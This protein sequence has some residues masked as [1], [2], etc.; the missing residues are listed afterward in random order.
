MNPTSL[1]LADDS[2]VARGGG[3]DDPFASPEGFFVK[4]SR[5][6]RKIPFIRQVDESDCGAACLAMVCRHFGRAV[7]LA[8][9]RDLTRTSASGTSLRSLCR[10]A[11]AL[12]LAARAVKTPAALLDRMP[13]PAIL[14]WEGNHWVLLY[15]VDAKNA[16]LADP[17]VGL[18]RVTR[19]ELERAFTGYAALFDYTTAFADSPVSQPGFAW[20]TAFLRPHARLVAQAIAL[21]VMVSVLELSFPVFTQLIVDR[22]IVDHN[23]T[24]LHTVVIAMAA[25]LGITVIA[26][27]VQRYLLSFV[28]VR[29]DGI[30]LDF[31]T[32]KLL[33]LPLPYF[34]ARRTGD[35]QRRLAS[36][37]EVRSFVVESGTAGLTAAANLVMALALMAFYSPRLFAVFLVTA[38][39]YAILMRYSS[40]RLGPIYA[41]LEAA[42]AKYGSQQIDAIKGIETVKTASAEASL[43]ARMIDQF[44]AVAR[45]QFHADFTMMSFDGAVRVVMFLSTALFL[46]IGAGE[47]MEGRLTLG[48]MVAW[49]AL[50][51]MANAPIATFLRIWDDLQLVSVLVNR[52]R[53]VFEHAPEQHDRR[54]H[55]QPVRSI[56][57][58]IRLEN[59]G[60][61]YAPEGAKILDGMLSLS[62]PRDPP[63]PP[64]RLVRPP[65]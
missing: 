51:G 1:P 54:D 48:A 27:L 28:A 50:V 42:F 23:L 52:L 39:L 56:T 49:S 10:A 11:T 4:R 13:L 61:R 2:P 60:F 14:H 17:A 8:R 20:V 12:G 16:H 64:S 25:V 15:D 41:E 22:A 53:D 5:K 34:L 29:F 59:V 44:H 30:T 26:T 63:Q 65:S 40:R 58:A 46:W 36:M 24:L 45:R 3:D 57:G 21:A 18:R 31:L 62:L 37:R 35:I 33:A 43:R 32:R 47:V 7:S 55:V 19:A 6:I 38:P 9:I